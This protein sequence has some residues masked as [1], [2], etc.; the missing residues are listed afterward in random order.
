MKAPRLLII[1]DNPAIHQDIGRI[2]QP[3]PGHC[4]PLTAL[5]AR[6]LGQWEGA[7]RGRAVAQVH[8]DYRVDSAFQG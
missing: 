1:D 5:E 4:A 8:L 3:P 2:L 6:M 7:D